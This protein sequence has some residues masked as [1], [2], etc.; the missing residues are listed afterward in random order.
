VVNGRRPNSTNR[1]S[2]GND[3]TLVQA[4]HRILTAQLALH[5]SGQTVLEVT[6]DDARGLFDIG[7]S[8]LGVWGLKSRASP[9]PS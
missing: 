2:L 7:M 5:R 6:E 4:F 8:A 9:R 3:P 1:F